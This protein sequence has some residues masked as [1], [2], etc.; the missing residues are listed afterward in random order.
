MEA[1]HFDD[2]IRK[3]LA[4][5][6]PPRY[7][8][9]MWTKLRNRIV[10]PSQ[11]DYKGAIAASSLLLNM[12]LVA[13]IW[14]N[15]QPSTEPAQ[16]S[17]KHLVTYDTLV[18]K[19]VVY[20]TTYRTIYL[21]NY[22]VRKAEVPDEIANNIY[23][24]NPGSGNKETVALN[25]P[26][27]ISGTYNSSIVN[28]SLT[29]LHTSA[30][31]PTDSVTSEQPKEDSLQTTPL[32]T[33]SSTLVADTEAKRHP[34]V[35]KQRREVFIS[36]I[37]TVPVASTGDANNVKSNL[38]SLELSYMPFNR[39]GVFGRLSS[40]HTRYSVE[41]NRFRI[42]ESGS[43]GNNLYS[44][45]NSSISHAAFGYNLGVRGIVYRARY[46]QATADLGY[47]QFFHDRTS[48]TNRLRETSSGKIVFSELPP[49]NLEHP[50]LTAALAAERAI[51]YRIKI[52]FGLDIAHNLNTRTTF[53]HI[54]SWGGLSAGLSYQLK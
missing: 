30:T 5:I 14:Q 48:I 44:Y 3:K 54:K 2:I 52:K 31:T 15:N 50:Y 40:Y 38:L 7:E 36:S 8:G 49:E 37:A 29:L 53:E 16:H 27:S 43:Y 46:W 4:N 26:Q 10:V 20:D 34:R 21:E 28:D 12:L 11:F 13:W 47:G 35:Y 33:D 6:E 18:Y 25:D 41:D 1:E 22:H 39:V 9:S 23:T 51:G 24:K 32:K 42:E 45:E 19:T 17:F